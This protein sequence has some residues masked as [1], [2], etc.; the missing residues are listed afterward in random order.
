MHGSVDEV[1]DMGSLVPHTEDT[2]R[3]YDECLI[4]RSLHEL[5]LLAVKLPYDFRV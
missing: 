2:D 3:W 5:G 4:E 1:A